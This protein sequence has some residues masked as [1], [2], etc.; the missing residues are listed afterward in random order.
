[1][2]RCSAS[3]TTRLE[4]HCKDRVCLRLRLEEPFPPCLVLFVDIVFFHGALPACCCSMDVW[5]FRPAYLSRLPRLS[6][7]PA[8]HRD[9]SGPVL[10][11]ACASGCLE[12]P[13]PLRLAL[14]DICRVVTAHSFAASLISSAA[15]GAGTSDCVCLRLSGGALSSA[16][17]ALR[18]MSCGLSSLVCCIVD[19]FCSFRGR[20]FGLRVPP[21]WSG[22]ALSPT[23]SALRPSL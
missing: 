22:G 18:H 13:S 3:A 2:L 8:W 21:V 10:R 4:H 7:R 15:F 17:G 12:E 11:T 6:L 9:F 1:M 14:F 19:F 20:N 16:F 5:L 23:F